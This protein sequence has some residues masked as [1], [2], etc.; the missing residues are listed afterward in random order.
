VYVNSWVHD[1]YTTPED[2]PEEGVTTTL[3]AK[4][5][6][7]GPNDAQGVVVM[8][9]TNK[10]NLGYNGWIQIGQDVID[11][12]DGGMT[13]ASAD[14]T[15][16]GDHQ[17]IQAKPVY[18]NDTDHSNDLGQ[19]NFDPHQSVFM[20]EAGTPYPA[21]QDMDVVIDAYQLPTDSGWSATVSSE[22]YLFDSLLIDN[23]GEYTIHVHI[24]EDRCPVM[25]RVELYRPHDCTVPGDA[26]NDGDVNIGDAVHLINYVFKGGPAPVCE[27]EFGSLT[28]DGE[29]DT[30]LIARQ[31]VLSYECASGDANADGTVNVADAVYLINYVF[32]G[33]PEPICAEY[34][35]F[36]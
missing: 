17:C 32:K 16:L 28:L 9:F 12:P 11:V 18:C 33:G 19:Q 24:D 1:I 22:D 13:E 3:V 30:V 5:R 31:T 29:I 14:W 26:N 6:N 25:I 36:R 35:T 23:P 20:I 34:W 10:N 4:V 2:P 27:G 8:F 15:P 21:P 7:D